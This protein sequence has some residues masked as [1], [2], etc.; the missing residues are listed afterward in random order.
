MPKLGDS[1]RGSM[2]ESL[3]YSSAVND[4]SISPNSTVLSP[5]SGG[6]GAPQ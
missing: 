1:V 4:M 5:S 3:S 2:V 6:E